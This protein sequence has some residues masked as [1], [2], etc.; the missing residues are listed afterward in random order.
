[1][2]SGK[3]FSQTAGTLSFSVLT[4]A[5]TGDYFGDNLLVIW[6]EDNTGTFIKTKVKYTLD[7]GVLDH[8]TTWTGKSGQNVVDATTGATRNGNSTVTFLWNGTNVAG[9]VV[10]DGIYKIWLEMAWGSSKVIGTGKT[11][12]SYSFT[13]NTTTSHQAPADLTF[14]KSVAID[15]TPLVT[16]IEGTLETKD[17]NVYPNPSS[18]LLKIDFKQPAA[19]CIVKIITNS[20]Q[21]AYT[22]RLTDIETGTRTLD[23][24]S[25]NA[26]NY[27]CVLHFPGRDVV[28]SVILVK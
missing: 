28:F 9:T 4:A 2:S 24:T 13:K 5:P 1:M 20:G 18:G 16:G 10:A 27:L 19:D 22:E 26:G 25:L 11:V 3:C 14:F 8:L 21:V 23:L 12:D 7:N 15:W 17:F 6:L